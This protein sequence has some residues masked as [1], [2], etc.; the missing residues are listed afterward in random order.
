MPRTKSAKKALRQSLTRRTKNIVRKRNLK[1][2]IK[3]I[4]KFITEK[5]TDEAKKTLPVLMKTVDKIAKTGL[6][7]KGKA[8][9]IKSRIA[10]RLNKTTS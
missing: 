1:N 4:Q 9:R 5:K 8:S 6:I 10:K 3:K 7:K 2:E